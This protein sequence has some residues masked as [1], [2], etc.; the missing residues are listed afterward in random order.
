M[1]DARIA[2]ALNKIIQNFYFKKKVSLEEHKAQK[3]NRFLR[4]RQIP[5]LIYDYFRVT[6]VGECVLDYVDLFTVVLR[7]DDIHEF[8]KRWDDILLSMAQFS[9]DDIL[10]SLYKLR[11][12]E[13]EKLKTLLDLYNLKIHQKKT[14][15]D[16]HRLKTMVKR[17]VEQNL[18]SR[19]FEG[20][21]ERI[22]EG[23]VVENQKQQRRVQRGQGE[24]WQ[25]K[26]NG[27]CSNGN[28]WSFR[29]D[30]DKRAK[31]TP[32]T[33]PSPEL[34]T[35]QHLRNPPRATSPRGRSPSWRISRL[36]CKDHF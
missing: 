36:P 31:C 32:P 14:K 27:Q 18:R 12:R 21:N 8:D 15:P 6:D 26:A 11:I 24:C 9:P 7:N 23:V 22:G 34:S 28:K 3:A 30:N 16:Y 35:P 2:S 17:N 1:L 19:N 13:S 25:W 10:E 33:A 4:G 29:H 20:R 5:H